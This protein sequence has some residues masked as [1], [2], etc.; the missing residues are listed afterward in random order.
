MS[1]KDYIFVFYFVGLYTYIMKNLIKNGR[2]QRNLL[3]YLRLFK[4]IF[5]C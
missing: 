2:T 1:K 5:F 3:F 4:V